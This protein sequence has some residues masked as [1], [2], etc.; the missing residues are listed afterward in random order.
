MGNVIFFHK[1]VQKTYLNTPEKLI[2]N[3]TLKSGF[4]FETKTK[5][6]KF[7]TTRRV[8]SSITGVRRNIIESYEYNTMVIWKKN[9]V[10]QCGHNTRD[11]RYSMLLMR[12]SNSVRAL[13]MVQFYNARFVFLPAGY[14]ITDDND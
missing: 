6:K 13:V 4:G 14:N 7:D 3:K 5:Q 1:T 2:I 11:I 12:R 10:H 8:T 9:A